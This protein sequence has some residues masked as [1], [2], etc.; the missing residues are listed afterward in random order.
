MLIFYLLTRTSDTAPSGSEPLEV[1]QH[2]NQENGDAFVGI[3]AQ[4]CADNSTHNRREI[5]RAAGVR[6]HKLARRE[7]ACARKTPDI[8]WITFTRIFGGSPH[9][10]RPMGSR[11]FRRYDP[12]HFVCT[13]TSRQP[14]TPTRIGE[15]GVILSRPGESL[16]ETFHLLVD[17]STNGRRSKLRYCGVY[18]T[19]NAPVD[20]Q[21]DDWHALPPQVSIVSSLSWNLSDSHLSQCRYI[22]SQL[23]RTSRPV[24]HIH[25][26]CTLRKRSGL[27]LNP[28][29]AEIQEWLQQ[30]NQGSEVMERR[31]IRDAFDSGAEVCPLSCADLGVIG[32][33]AG[34]AHRNFVSK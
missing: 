19:V 29:P 23:I 4:L 8:P 7:V 31:A 9:S 13:N 14:F 1:V 32:L 27:G 25:A 33:T 5:F 26:R 3:I 6:N 28:P 30:Y 18:I 16:H 12:G 17:L 11:T 10:E 2:G 22:S 21:V 34:T 15:P 24:G 20:V